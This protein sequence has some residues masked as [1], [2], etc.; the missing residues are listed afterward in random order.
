MSQKI[1]RVMTPLEWGLLLTLSV[2]WGGAFFLQA[3]AVTELAP[4]VLVVSRT[5]IAAVTLVIVLLATRQSFPSGRSLWLPFLVLG[6][7]SNVVPFS[8]IAWAQTQIG[9]GLASI[10]NAVTPLTTVVAAHF[11]TSDEKMTPARVAGVLVGLAGVIIMIGGAALRGLDAN[12]LAQIAVLLAGVSYAFA[13]IYGRRFGRMGVS[14]V[15]AATGQVVVATALLLPAML[16]VDRPWT[17]PMPSAQIWIAV[18]VL[19]TVST[20]V[21]YIIF[22]RILAT[23]GATNIML[24]TLLIPVSAILLGTLILHERLEA[25]HFVGMAFIAAGLAMIDGRILRYV[26]FANK[27]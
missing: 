10:L 26:R 22:F 9:A 8:L 20:A 16:L 11:L 13:S 3:V 15:Q 1:N 25:K 4:L 5:G 2:L 23:A 7:L 14:P 19:G 21:A 24:V 18:F 6:F 12:V 27:V 17:L